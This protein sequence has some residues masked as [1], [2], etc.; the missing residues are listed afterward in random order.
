MNLKHSLLLTNQH[1]RVYILAL[2]NVVSCLSKQ[3]E[4]ER[5]RGL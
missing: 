5:R 1:P 4:L 2:V 3:S